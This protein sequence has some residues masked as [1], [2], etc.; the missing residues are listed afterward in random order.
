M[1]IKKIENGYMVEAYLVYQN[2]PEHG[3]VPSQWADTLPVLIHEDLF[4]KELRIY[5]EEAFVP[6]ADFDDIVPF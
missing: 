1:N 4:E 6:D 3:W 5:R 2:D